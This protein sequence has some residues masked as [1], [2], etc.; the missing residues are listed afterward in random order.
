[1]TNIQNIILAYLNGETIQYRDKG[2]DKPWTNKHHNVDVG[3]YPTDFEYRIKPKAVVKYV[4][5]AHFEEALKSNNFLNEKPYMHYQLNGNPRGIKLTFID[6]K[7]TE[8][9]VV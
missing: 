6:G 2:T 8:T 3:F 4:L 5:A 1:M 7:L 9:E